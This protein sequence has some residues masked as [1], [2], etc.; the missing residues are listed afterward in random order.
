M[1]RL[2]LRGREDHPAP[3]ATG[4]D[5]DSGVDPPG[6]ALRHPLDDATATDR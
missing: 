2:T 4:Q 5:D 3:V 1:G 6:L